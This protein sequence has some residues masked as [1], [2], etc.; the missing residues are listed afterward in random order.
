[1]FSGGGKKAF[2]LGVGA[3]FVG[4]AV[5]GGYAMHTY[6]RYKTYQAMMYYKM[7]GGWGDG[8]GYGGGYGYYRTRPQ[9]W[10]GCPIGSYC[11]FGMC[12]CRPGYED[13]YGR[14]W[15]NESSFNRR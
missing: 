2:A 3:G 1:M 13:I 11:D 14:C 5:A 8:Y 12:S 15:D 4:G 10:G 7:H 6:H 9:C